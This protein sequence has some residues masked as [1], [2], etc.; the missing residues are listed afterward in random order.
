MKYGI[1]SFFVF[2]LTALIIILLKIPLIIFIIFTAP[3]LL[4][5]LTYTSF[6]YNFRESLQMEPIPERGYSSR[7]KEL[8]KDQETI[9]YSL[10]FRKIDQ[11]YLKTIPN[12]VTY[13]FK[14]KK[15]PIYFCI[16]HLGK[17]MAC[18]FL[19]RYENDMYL[20]TSNVIDAG[21]TP[22]PDKYF[23]QIFPGK[24]Y[25]DLYNEHQKSHLFLNNKGVRTFNMAEGEFRHYFMKSFFEQGAY[26]R[27]FFLWPI[28]LIFRT[29]TQR[30]RVFCKPIIDQH[31]QGKIK[32]FDS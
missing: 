13:V 8:E 11:F 2:I 27:K 28:R 9:Q 29:I 15:E 19:T 3:L 24:S 17:K 7:T 22:R 32:I 5:V 12:S 16:Y 20:T 30:G 14:H 21:M 31:A 25:K 23:L 4:I 1:W 26:I 18:D 6:L 10:D